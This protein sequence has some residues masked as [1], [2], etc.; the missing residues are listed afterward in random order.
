MLKDFVK[1]MNIDTQNQKHVQFHGYDGVSASISLE[2]ALSSEG[3]VLIAL[4]MNDDDIP[5]DHGF[6]ARIIVPGYVGIRN[7]KWVQDIVFSSEEAQSP[8]QIGFSYKVLPKYV[9]DVNLHKELVKNTKTLQSLPVQSCIVS[10]EKNV[11][12]GFASHTVT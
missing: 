2:K 9:K 1:E 12:R 8:Q 5:V 10:V 11:V 7:I 6:P 3:D 4:K